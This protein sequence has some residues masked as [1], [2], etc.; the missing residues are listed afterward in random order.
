[1]NVVSG[2]TGWTQI[3][4]GQGNH[5]IAAFPAAAAAAAALCN[6]AANDIAFTAD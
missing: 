1:M 3:A 2:A 6:A 5:A 4:D